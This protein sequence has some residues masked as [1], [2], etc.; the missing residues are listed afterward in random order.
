MADE[1]RQQRRARQRDWLKIGRAAFDDGLRPEP[2]REEVYGAALVL[3]AKLKERGNVTRASEAAGLAQKLAEASRASFAAKEAVACAKG[4]A[5][6]CH[7]YVGV[8]PPEVFAI[9]RAIRQ[10][11]R[12]GN[13]FLEPAA[14][15]ERGRATRD[16]SPEERIGAKIACQLL[17]TAGA[18]SVY[19]VRPLVCRQTASFLV[20]ACKS[21]LEGD[22]SLMTVPNRHMA[23]GSNA[24]L[25][26]LAAMKSVGMPTIG[27]EL[28]AALEVALTTPDA[29]ARWLAGDTIFS[30]LTNIIRRPAA[31]E[32]VVARIAD[33]VGG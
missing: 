14:V 30:A 3:R 21:E 26:L 9:A 18:C 28:A 7:N 20:E 23:A 33:E 13:T 11:A 10:G 2:R 19:A 8:I 32:G 31:V 17:G 4:C 29:E 6:C 1:S 24:H 27:Y 15:L 16:K 25:A 22:R 5:H 12:Q